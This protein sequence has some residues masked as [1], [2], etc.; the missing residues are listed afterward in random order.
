MIIACHSR[1]CNNANSLASV[2]AVVAYLC[3]L[4]NDHTIVYIA[5]FFFSKLV[6]NVFILR[7]ITESIFY[8]S[9]HYISTSKKGIKCL[10]LNK[11]FLITKPVDVV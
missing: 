10:F 11:L 6:K 4:Y 1:S 5:H 7:K 3:Y 9:L 2:T 8:I